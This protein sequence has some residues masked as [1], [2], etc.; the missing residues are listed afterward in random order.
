MLRLLLCLFLIPL[1]A[2]C[3]TEAGKGFLPEN[4]RKYPVE[5]KTT[6]LS[7]EQ[8]NAVI[9]KFESFYAPVAKRFGAKLVIERKWESETVNAGTL[10][11]DNGKTWVINLYG[12]YARHPDT[13]ADSYMLVLCHEIGHHIGGAPKK[14]YES[15]THWASTEG[16]S[17]YFATLKCLRKIFRDEENEEIVRELDIPESIRT[18]CAQSFAT[19]AQYSLCLRTSY[20]GIAVSKVNADI[21]NM[22][23]PEIDIVDSSIV[24]ATSNDHPVPQ[25]RLNTYF[26]GAL[27]PVPVIRPVSQIDDVKGTCHPALEYSTGLRPGCWYKAKNK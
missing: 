20:A 25:C 14:V 23:D 13:T 16:Q 17:D 24:S 21:R 8:Y 7:V 19:K 22:P 3:C 9:D 1:K 10:R 4:H 18:E 26:Q 15:G 6:G 2:F 11:R 5:F 27:C 12:G